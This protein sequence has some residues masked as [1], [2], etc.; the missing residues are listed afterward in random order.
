MVGI[1]SRYHQKF[2]VMCRL[3]QDIATLSTC[4]RLQVGAVIVDVG[5]TQVLSIGYNGPASGLP[6]DSC[7]GEQGSCGCIHAEANALIKL[8]DRRPSFL[9]ATHSPCVH[10]AGLIVNAGIEHVFYF[11]E[12]RIQSGLY[13]KIGNHNEVLQRWYDM[14]RHRRPS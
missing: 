13:T 7:T 10:C 4:K 9:I 6:N 3:V 2:D 14:S 8:S 1:E 5:F 11:N 12:Y